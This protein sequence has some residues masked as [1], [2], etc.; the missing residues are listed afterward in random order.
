M[1]RP[2]GDAVTFHSSIAADFADR[3]EMSEQFRDRRAVWFDAIES[4]GQRGFTVDLGCGAGQL[5]EL[6]VATSE[7]VLAIDGSAE[8]IELCRA[9]TGASAEYL[10]ARFDVLDKDRLRGADL[11]I[12]SSVLEYIAEPAEL[13][14]SLSSELAPEAVILVSI[15]NR[16]SVYR[17]LERGVF[18]VLKR[19]GYL[20]YA[21]SRPEPEELTVN[22]FEVHSVRY[23][24]PAP[25]VGGLAR[26]FRLREW[27]DTLV[28]VELRRSTTE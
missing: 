4:V 22:G 17:L 23:L 18:A 26:R 12:A 6:V 15:P 25:L 27:F 16:R 10:C 7:R 24:S 13:L 9:R 1:T 19:P 8:M 3:Y 5:T 11:L 2:A 28:L 20:A 14:R 21:R